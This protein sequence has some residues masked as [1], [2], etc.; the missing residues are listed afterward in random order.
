MSRVLAWRVVS[1]ILDRERSSRT[2]ALDTAEGETI[3]SRCTG[4][5]ILPVFLL[6][7]FV[8][9]LAISLYRR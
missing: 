9:I 1:A 7:F 5:S 4:K 6:S 2:K 8:P 3:A